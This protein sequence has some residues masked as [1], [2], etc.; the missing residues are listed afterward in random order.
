LRL[1]RWKGIFVIA[2]VIRKFLTISYSALQL[3]FKRIIIHKRKLDQKHQ[4]Y[5]LVSGRT[6]IWFD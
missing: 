5:M 1:I 3:F 2:R 4:D 6:Y